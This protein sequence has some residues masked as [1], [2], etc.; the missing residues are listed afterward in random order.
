M[1]LISVYHFQYSSVQCFLF[2]S[3]FIF[4]L[5]GGYA[6]KFLVVRVA[7]TEFFQFLYV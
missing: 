5:P 4:L 1:L 7:A 3:S 6:L 2:P